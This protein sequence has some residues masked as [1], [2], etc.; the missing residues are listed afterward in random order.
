IN[1]KPFLPE[2]PLPVTVANTR[3]NLSGRVNQLLE[4]ESFEADNL[5][6]LV[7][8]LNSFQ[9]TANGN[10]IIPGSRG[11]MNFNAN[12]NLGTNNLQAFATANGISLNQILPDS[13]L[14]LPITANN[15]RVNVTG[16]IDQ[17]LANNFD[18]LN[19]NLNANLDVARGSVS[20]IANLNKGRIVSNINAN[21]VQT[22]LICVRFNIPCPQLE[23]LSAKFN[24]AGEV[25]PL[26]EGNPVVIQ[27]NRANVTTQ[28]QKLNANGQIV[29]VP[30]DEGISSWN[31]ATNLNVDVNS[32]LSRLPLKTIALELDDELIP[33]IQGRADF[34]G[35]LIGRNLISA[36]FA[37][38]NV[39]LTGNLGLK[40]F[41]LDKI[42]FQ[43]LL[44]GPL[45]LNL[46]NNIEIDLQGKTDRIAASLQPCNRK[47]CLSPYLPNLF[48]LKQ[49]VNTQNP[50]I[51]SGRRQ[52]DVLD[53]DLKNAS[54][55]L[56]NLIP[57]VEETIG[58]TVGGTISGYLDV[59]LFNLATAGNIKVDKPS[60]GAVT[61]KEFV[62]DF[63]YDGK[64]AR[65]DAANLQ[66][67]QTRY[68]LQ[69]GF[70][71]DTW[72]INGKLVADSAR[73]QDIFAAVNVFNLQD[74][75]GGINGIL[76]H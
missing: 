72:D 33:K 46:G 16:K 7:N 65:V 54:L 21:N 55:A 3:V 26:L 53:I 42:A 20:A 67:G 50:V 43:P 57:V 38:G 36:P 5:N 56:L 15:T 45:D 63:S 37:P 48:A 44:K 40:N 29:V 14:P 17:L 73:V 64:I 62:A 10:L 71:L 51:L 30:G 1:T 27:A 60:I 47:N 25:K 66:I 22:P 35:R 18:N 23:A 31:L 52:G 19:A 13:I 49:G 11:N 8:Q 28:G 32:N 58:T 76:N 34:S 74:L 69:G 4:L 70:N 75:Q 59:N 9:V 12:G 39:R 6:K 61:A 41:T 68:A 24:L 2:L